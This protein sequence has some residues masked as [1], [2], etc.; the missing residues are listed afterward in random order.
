MVSLPR[1]IRFTIRLH[2]SD[3]WLAW[4]IVNMM[5]IMILPFERTCK[6]KV[7]SRTPCKNKCHANYSMHGLWLSFG[8]AEGH[9][10]TCLFVCLFVWFIDG[11][12]GCLVGWLVGWVGW[13]VGWLID[14][15]CGCEDPFGCATIHKY[16]L[17]VW[18]IFH[19]SRN[20]G[21]NHPNWRNHIFQ[22]GR[23]QPPTISIYYP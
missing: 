4:E 20:I 16:W 12:I 10:D 6:V 7:S 13:L 21:N 1:S 23:A 19:F 14:W 22:R 17:V 2:L 8:R 3:G 9:T 11:L 5:K 15:L 18:N